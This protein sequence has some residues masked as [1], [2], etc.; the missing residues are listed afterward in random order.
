MIIVITRKVPNRIKGFISQHLFSIDNKIFVGNMTEETRKKFLI[1][2]K[3]DIWRNSGCLIIWDSK[4]VCGYDFDIIGC[5][6][7]GYNLDQLDNI[8][9]F[10]KKIS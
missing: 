9:I 10:K 4:N 3:T 2:L 7:K 8:K 1:S 6:N 5:Y